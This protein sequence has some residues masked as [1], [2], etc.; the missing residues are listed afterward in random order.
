MLKFHKH[1]SVDSTMSAYLEGD[2]EYLTL[3][4]DVE[5]KETSCWC[6][7]SAQSKLIFQECRGWLCVPMLWFDVL[8]EVIPSVLSISFS[9]AVLWSLSRFYM[10]E[11]ENSTEMA[12]SVR[13]WLSSYAGNISGSFGWQVPTGSDDGRDEKESKNSIKASTMCLPPQ[14]VIQMEH[15]ELWRQWTWEPR[16]AESMIIMLLDP[17]DVFV[18]NNN[19]R[20]VDRLILEHVSKTQGLSCALQFLCTSGS[21]LSAISSGLKHALKLVI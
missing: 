16:M 9:K 1:P 20:Q 15:G 5:E 3:S 4:E 11:P 8:V 6:E 13:D 12:L 7:F 21:S 18:S 14:F 10:V 17:N 19:V 2:E